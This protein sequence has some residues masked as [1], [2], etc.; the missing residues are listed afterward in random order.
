MFLN[1][2]LNVAGGL[3]LIV[4]STPATVVA[5]VPLFAVYYR[6]QVCLPAALLN[7]AANGCKLVH[8]SADPV[9][10]CVHVL[11]KRAHESTQ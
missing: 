11:T 6:V 10:V 4:L 7:A 1:S 2:L 8:H 9:L 5:L 3:G